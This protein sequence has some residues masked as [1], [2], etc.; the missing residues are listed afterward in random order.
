MLPVHYFIFYISE[1][2][3]IITSTALKALSENSNKLLIS[4]GI[5]RFNFLV[6]GMIASFFYLLRAF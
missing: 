1:T 3:L 2:K 5:S 4:V 6:L